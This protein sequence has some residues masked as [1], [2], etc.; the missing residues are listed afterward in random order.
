MNLLRSLYLGILA[1]LRK[2]KRSAELDEELAAYLEA[3]AQEKMRRGMT[4]EEARRAARVEMGSIESVK[5]EVR[6]SGW[7][8]EADSF[9]HDI[10]YGIRQLRRSPGFSATAILMLA[11]GI[12]VNTA[13]FTLVHAVMLKPLPVA[14][15]EQLYRIGQGE[16][17]CCEW[18]GLQEPWGTFPWPFYEHVRGN[19]SVFEQVAAFSGGTPS[20]SVRR[21]G[22]SEPSQTITTEFVSG[23]YFSTFGLRSSAGRLLTPDDNTPQ[24]P[25]VAVMSHRAWKQRYSSDPSLVGAVL[26]VNGLP[27]TLVGIAPPGFDGARLTTSPP[28]LWIPLHQEP[29]F[30][31][32]SILRSAGVAW[33]YMIGRLKPDSPP[34]QVQAQLTAELQH[35][36]LAN[37]Y[38]RFGEQAIQRQQ[39]PLTPGGT[40]VSSF[41]SASGMGL[42]LLSAA[43]ALVLLI[44]CANLA[45]LLMARGVSRQHQTALRLSLGATPRRLIQALLTESVLLSVCGGA[46]G[47]MVSWAATKGMLLLIFRGATWIPVDPSPSLPVL[48]F[49][50]LISLITGVFF[51]VAPAWSAVRTQPV[52]ALRSGSRTTGGHSTPRSVFIVAQAA[53]S[54]VLLTIAGMFTQSLNNIE[55]ADL[56]FQPE[57]RLV[58]N[59]NFRAAGY[60]PEQLP[61]LYTEVQRRLEEIPGVRSA[62]LSFNSPQN[63]C[64]INLNIS[65]GG[66]AEKWIEDVNV[67]FNRV[68]PGYFETMG[69]PLIRGRAFSRQDTPSS[70]KVAIVDQSFAN[71][72][73]PG[74]DP[75]GKHFGMSL[76]GHGYDYEIVGVVRDTRYRSPKATQSPMYFLPFSQTTEYEPAGYQRL[77]E[78]THYAQAVEIRVKRL[79]DAYEDTFRRALAS[80][81]PNAAI[82]TVKTYS[83][84]VAVQFNQDRLVARLT[85][86]FSLLAVLVASVGLYGVTAWS[87]SRRTGE[88][89]I[90]MA[91]GAGRRDVVA[92]VLRE[93]MKQAGIG[94]CIG[95][96]VAILCGRYV[97]GQLYAVRL[98]DPLAPVSAALVLSVCALLAAIIPARRA[99][100]IA[101]LDALRTE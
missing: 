61:A 37:G 2:D 53:L 85:A 83:E 99:A 19:M 15:P 47:L 11:L 30:A 77:E 78:G 97:S 98:Y 80:V 79:P 23:N 48:G 71:R 41:R 45:N 62:S 50:F 9:L 54:I 34:K 74:E 21:A 25:A 5:Q 93:A 91:L 39:I 44:A 12:G 82:A 51:G 72:F 81:S 55:K 10:R 59:V 68:T 32:N 16:A 8:F 58:A 3:A 70:T 4:L 22:S 64:C 40:G 49:A 46:V 33:L 31:G 88:I 1:L 43:S 20:Y 67:L 89:G 52:E 73:F 75:I 29:A 18:G 76:A 84:Q 6:A 13:I 57:G 101:P 42:Y 100:S 60:T 56:G 7:E 14:V 28:E 90:R 26:L 96:P 65:I 86:L 17:Y 63:L 24:A 27:V 92:M 94:L 38:Q 95:I 87:V 36:L 69:T 66:R 35:W